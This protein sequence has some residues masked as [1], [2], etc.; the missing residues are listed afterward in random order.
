VMAVH[1]VLLAVRPEGCVGQACDGGVPYR[2]SEDVSWLF[3]VAVVLLTI[4]AAGARTVPR[5]GR[6]VTTAT[7]AVGVLLL[8]VGIVVNA[9]SSAGS[10]LWWL[11]DSD[12][13]GRFIPLLATGIAGV[14]LLSARRA[15]LGS[16]LLAAF[17]IGLP[18]NIQDWRVLLNL[19]M[20]AAWGVLFALTVASA[21]RGA[22]ELAPETAS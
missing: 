9:G 21:H 6:I 19:P 16:L 8:A 7:L 14:A 4:A 11:Y 12:T 18:F 13:L 17:V 20:A 1:A 22:R 2:P 15:W 5:W 10:P 3:L